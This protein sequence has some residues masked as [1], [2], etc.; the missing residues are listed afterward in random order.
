[1]KLMFVIKT[2]T[3]GTGGAERV[4]S[5]ITSELCG[6]GHEVSLVTF[7]S[8]GQK[9]FYAL[10]E[11]IRRIDLGLGDPQKKSGVAITLK[12][13]SALRRTARSEQPDAVIAFMHSAFVPAAFAFVGTGIPV[14][15]S[16][17]IVPAYYDRRKLE[18]AFFQ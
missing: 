12:R 8:L 13:I 9:P 3:H 2:M 14:I 11:R 1:M 6:L 5:Q 18:F 17:H 16:E 15:G 7:D 4:L 10:D